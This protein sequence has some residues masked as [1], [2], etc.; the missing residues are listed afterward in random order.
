MTEDE[1]KTRWCPFVRL[2]APADSQFAGTLGNRIGDDH[3]GNLCCIASKCMAWRPYE[4]AAFRDKAA[5]EFRHRGYR[6]VTDEG[7]CGLARNPLV[8]DV[9][10][11]TKAEGGQ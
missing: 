11:D 9:A 6:L 10:T 5:A 2:A 1:A 3:G 4:S 8:I 7:F